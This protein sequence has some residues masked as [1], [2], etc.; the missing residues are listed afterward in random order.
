MPLPEPS[1][2][3]SRPHLSA[4]GAKVGALRQ[5]GRLHQRE[6]HWSQ[7]E[8]NTS[9]PARCASQ[10]ELV[11]AATDLPGSRLFPPPYS[12]GPD[13]RRVA[14]AAAGLLG[15]GGDQGPPAASTL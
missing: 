13:E 6:C 5:L 10:H 1:A 15:P 11:V 3:L 4:S 14:R 2:S 8:I 7:A 9:T 12:R